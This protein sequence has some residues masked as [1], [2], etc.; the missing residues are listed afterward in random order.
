MNTAKNCRICGNEISPFMTF[1]QMPIANG[2]LKE[3][4]FSKEYFFEMKPS[5]CK[6]CFAFQLIDQPDASMMFNENYPFFSSL[7]KHMQLHFEKFAES[8]IDNFI[9]DKSNSFVIEL[10]SNDGIMLK[11]FKNRGIKHLGVEPS[12]NVAEISANEGI[13]TISEFFDEDLAD[14]ILDEY[15][16]ANIIYAANVM[17]HIPDLNSVFRGISKLLGSNGVLVFEDPY[18]GEML[19]KV[20]YDQIY[21][22]HVYIFSASSV[23][24]LCERHGLELIDAKSQKTHGGSMRYFIA[25]KGS[26]KITKDI[27]DLIEDE[28]NKG[29][30]SESIYLS[31][32]RDCEN[33]KK[34]L[35]ALLQRLKHEDKRVVGYGA[36]SKSTTIL[37]Y[38]GIGPNLIEYISDTT[39]LKQNKFS[40]GIHI[41][42]KAY[43]EFQNNPP[44]YAVL[45]AWNHLEEIMGKEEDFIKNGGKWV[46]HVP[47]VKI[48]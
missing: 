25:P 22:E 4:E 1:G 40:P 31:F 35:F 3:H 8:L 28:N 33:S 36:T 23:S 32:K 21:D 38:S 11:H 29:F 26:H 42:I 46:T 19:K 44:D 27:T 24:S 16:N 14:K 15:G 7:S 6:N 10:G 12:S 9:K 17:C 18:L 5:F 20:S 45:F 2:F 47:V 48:I 37:N 39:P 43:E 13:N 34:D 41:P 30:K